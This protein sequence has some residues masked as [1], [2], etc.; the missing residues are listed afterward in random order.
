M[1]QIKIRG[2]DENEITK[3]SVGLIDKLVEEIQCSRDAFEIEC[4]KSVAIRE[5]KIAPVYPFVEIAWFDRGLEVQ[6]KVAKIVTNILKD[7]LNIPDLDLAFTILDRRSFYE[8][9][10]HFA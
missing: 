4:I 7:E 6:D 10:K 2:I 1:P 9:G 5:G 3:V 8:N